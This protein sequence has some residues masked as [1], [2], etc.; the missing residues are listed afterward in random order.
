VSSPVKANDHELE[1]RD[2]PPPLNHHTTYVVY[3]Y[4]SYGSAWVA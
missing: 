3:L 4:T 1:L 2:H